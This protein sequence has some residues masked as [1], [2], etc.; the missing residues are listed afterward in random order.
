M[1]NA[2][3]LEQKGFET[4]DPGSGAG[5][6]ASIAKAHTRGEP[7][8]GYYW[9]PTAVLGKYEMVKVD[10]GSGTDKEEYMN[11]TTQAD[12]LNP[13]VTMY[14]PS[15]VHSITTENFAVSSPAAYEYITKRSIANADMNRML[16]WVENN[17]ADGELAAEHF[18][19]TYPSLWTQWVPATVAAKVNKALDEL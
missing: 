15:A 13:K 8:F 1:F 5:L 16:A 7:W 6:A 17:Q 11:C 9:S 3:K 14:P 2:L 18:L 10:F 12:C 19:I 4:I